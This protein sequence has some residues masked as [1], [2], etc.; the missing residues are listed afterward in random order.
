MGT[1]YYA[2]RNACEHCGRGD[3]EL[4]IGKS[5]GGW[6]FSFQAYKQF[7][8]WDEKEPIDNY[9]KWISVLSEPGVVLRNEYGEVVSLEEFMKLVERKKDASLN[10]TDCVKHHP[11][12]SKHH[13][14]SCWLDDKGHSFC[15]EILVKVGESG[16][17]TDEWLAHLFF[18]FNA[19]GE[20]L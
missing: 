15:W 1:N 9:D 5:S 3:D 14:E 20:F 16:H 12:W 6:T 8:T 18:G 19:Y 10:Y 13:G 7:E 17:E 11:I 2:Y 4:H